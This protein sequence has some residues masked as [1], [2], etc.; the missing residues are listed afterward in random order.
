MAGYSVSL[1]G[2]VRDTYPRRSELYL[3]VYFTDDEGPYRLESNQYWAAGRGFYRLKEIHPRLSFPCSSFTLAGLQSD[4]LD[5][6]L[7]FHNRVNNAL[8]ARSSPLSV[9][10]KRSLPA[11]GQLQHRTC[12]FYGSAAED[13]QITL[14]LGLGDSKRRRRPYI[15]IYIGIYGNRVPRRRR[16]FNALREPGDPESARTR[17]VKFPSANRL[18]RIS[19]NLPITLSRSLF[20]PRYYTFI[21]ARERNDCL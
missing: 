2:K 15:Y 9:T 18:I 3:A 17:T 14:G 11:F 5:S 10:Q 8:P 12:T 4:L 1:G 16:R 21:I 6:P 7:P 13:L 20:I 19:F